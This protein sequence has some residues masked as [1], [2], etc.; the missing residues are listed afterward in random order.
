MNSDYLRAG[1][2][3]LAVAAALSATTGG[4]DAQELADGLYAKI[5]TGRGDIVLRLEYEKTPMTVMNFV[6]LAEGAIR[7]DGRSGKPFYDGLKFNR[8]IADFMI[9]GGDPAGTGSGGPGY[10]FPD[11]IDA[12]LRHSGPGVLSMANRGPGT[13][14][15]QFFITHKETPW[16]DGK[17]TVFGRVVSGQDVVDKIRQGDVMKKVTIIRQGA[18]A[19]A[20]AA[21]QAAFDAAVRSAGER[22]ARKVEDEKKAVFARIEELLP[23]A[24]KSPS[25]DRKSVV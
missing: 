16:L 1:A 2:K 19:K 9:Q 14:G 12:S 8:V 22:A 6:G 17:H 11:E 24:Q 5:S 20:F 25:G 13:N 23:G 21:D 7:A 10:T 4:L 18:K 3:A 15:S